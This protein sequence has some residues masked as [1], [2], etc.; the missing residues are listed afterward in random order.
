MCITEERRARQLTLD[1]SQSGSAPAR[2]ASTRNRHALTS[3]AKPIKRVH[4]YTE[5]DIRITV[6]YTYVLTNILARVI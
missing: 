3:R 4:I 1:E 2:I 6:I 5:K